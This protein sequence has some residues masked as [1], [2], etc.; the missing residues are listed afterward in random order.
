MA[1]LMQTLL[2]V[3]LSWYIASQDL[4]AITEPAMPLTTETIG[5]RAV[6]ILLGSLDS[7]EVVTLPTSCARHREIET[8]TGIP[9]A[10]IFIRLCR[11]D[12]KGATSKVNGLSLV[13]VSV[14]KMVVP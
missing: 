1:A 2:T 9:I 11:C 5:T 13:Y 14:C 7:V 8:K 6:V 4:T 10:P 3:H 12:R